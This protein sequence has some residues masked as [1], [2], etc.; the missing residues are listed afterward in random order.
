MSKTSDSIFGVLNI[1]RFKD[2][3]DFL[4]PRRSKRT[5]VPA[6]PQSRYKTTTI[7]VQDRTVCT[8]EPL[9]SATKTHIVYFH[10]GGYSMEASGLHF[11]L[12]KTLMKQTGCPLTYV[13]YPLAPEH[14][15]LDT[16]GM[17]LAA[18]KQLLEMYPSHR[19]VFV[20]DSAGGG[21]ALALGMKIREE[22]IAG[23]V[24]LILFSP[25]LDLTLANEQIPPLEDRDVIL[26]V[27]ALREI[28][29]RYR[30][31]IPKDHYLVSPMYGDLA[32]LGRIAVFY[33]TEEILYPDCRAFCER[34]A[35]KVAAAGGAGEQA[36]FSVTGFEYQGMQHDWVLLP[37][38]E[39][40]KAIAEACE[41]IVNSVSVGN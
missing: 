40:K 24:Q 30:G 9:D 26:D 36:G 41:I 20:G 14:T 19:F 31:D 16:V 5:R 2:R 25:W 6:M 17:C 4:N 18:Y 27:A 39:A 23:P 32:G 33:G 3:V 34:A 38:E 22:G 12:M 15:A 21:L 1:I 7:L 8:I 13:D 11:Q 10:G 29:E 35:E 28:G 37:M